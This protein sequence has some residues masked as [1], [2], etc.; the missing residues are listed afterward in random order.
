MA[1]CLY[2]PDRFFVFPLSLKISRIMSSSPPFPVAL[3]DPSLLDSRGLINGKFRRAPNEK[4]FPVY[5]P[6]TGQVLYPC[7]NFDREDFAEA[8][9]IAHAGY[10]AFNES[11][12]AKGRGQMLHRWNDLILENLNDCW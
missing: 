5:E 2:I 9:N 7:A 12:T 11:T 6:A 1:A 8:I 3:R 4:T 10:I